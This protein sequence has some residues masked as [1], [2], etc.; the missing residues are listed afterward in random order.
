MWVGSGKNNQGD[1]A[2]ATITRKEEVTKK[3]QGKKA[4]IATKSRKDA[5]M[6]TYE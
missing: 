3:Y 5:G 4:A 2:A 6:C 1:V